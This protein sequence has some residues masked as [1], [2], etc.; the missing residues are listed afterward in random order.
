MGGE[1]PASPGRD[2]PAGPPAEISSELNKRHLAKAAIA[3]DIDGRPRDLATIIDH[4]A[5]VAIITP[6]SPQGV[7]I[8]RHDAPPLVSFW[9]RQSPRYLEKWNYATIQ[10]TTEVTLMEERLASGELDLG[11]LVSFVRLGESQTKLVKEFRKALRGE[12]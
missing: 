3:I 10:S 4:D 7:E 6:D 8:L 2:L 5:R 1:R 11:L 12:R 9:Y